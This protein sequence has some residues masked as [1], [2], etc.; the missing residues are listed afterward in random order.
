MG[1]LWDLHLRER[2][3][4]LVVSA[5]VGLIRKVEV[6]S[7]SISANKRVFFKIDFS[8]ASVPYFMPP[9][10]SGKM[11]FESHD[12]RCCSFRLIRSNQLT[13][14]ERRRCCRYRSTLHLPDKLL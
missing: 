10:G 7:P 4:T 3:A 13:K 1:V 14:L 9:H 6:F 8:V 5:L 12:H 2:F 11:T